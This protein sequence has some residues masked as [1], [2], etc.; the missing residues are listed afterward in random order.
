MILM[1]KARRASCLPFRGPPRR[2]RIVIIPAS[3][4]SS[5]YSSIDIP[6][7]GIS[8]VITRGISVASSVL[9]EKVGYSLLSLFFFIALS[10]AVHGVIKR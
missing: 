7:Y 2:T 9:I 3:M 8:R 4:D 10:F 5:G 6:R 1:T